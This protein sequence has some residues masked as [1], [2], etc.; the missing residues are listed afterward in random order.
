MDSFIESQRYKK[1]LN[2]VMSDVKKAFLLSQLRRFEPKSRQQIPPNKLI[3]NSIRLFR[4]GELEFEIILFGISSIMC[5]G[6]N[7]NAVQ[8][9]P[10]FFR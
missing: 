7:N 1:A 6:S 9:I 8:F 5:V 10:Q 4:R 3:E 2:P